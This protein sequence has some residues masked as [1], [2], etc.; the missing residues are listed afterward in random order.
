MEELTKQ[1][2]EACSKDAPAVTQEEIA[3]LKPQIPDW[4]I[5]ELRGRIALGA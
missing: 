3:Q 5:I 1:K 4:E 2:C